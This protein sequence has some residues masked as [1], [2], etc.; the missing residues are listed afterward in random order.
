MAARPAGLK[1]VAQ[2]AGVSVAAA[3]QALSGKGRLS[4]DTRAR[5]L[6]VADHL[7]YTRHPAASA[8]AGGRSRILALS[9]PEIE[10]VPTLAGSIQH[11]LGVLGGAAGAALELDHSLVVAPGGP[12]EAGWSR[13]TFDG[14]VVVDPRANEPVLAR[15]RRADVPVV[16]IG[17][18]PGA[19]GAVLHVDNDVKAMT[20]AVLDFLADRG[21]QRI[22]LMISKPIFSVE[23]DTVDAAQS[24][25]EQHSQTLDVVTADSPG[26]TA[27]RA[28]AAELFARP[29]P[30]DAIYATLDALAVAAKLEAE[31]HGLAVPAGLQLMT[32]SN[33]E[34]TRH[35][36]LS[37][38]D[39]RPAELG[40]AAVRLLIDHLERRTAP[41]RRT[42][43]P[44][45]LIPRGST[46]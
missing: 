1:E 38:V 11:F 3:S 8:L 9:M 2:A 20:R 24:W 31:R 23:A 42:E 4:T 36:D 25:C 29:E 27:V 17:R 35:H 14:A 30:P 19:R 45:T 15:L 44:F 26:P 37:T 46:R 6:E 13:L 7:G 39:E 12:N 41:E 5:I 18:E 16:T 22:G 32:L 43:V 10:F 34:L 21:A 28:A 40:S 33:S